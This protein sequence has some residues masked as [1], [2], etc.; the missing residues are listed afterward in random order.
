MADDITL[1]GT[2]PPRIVATDEDGSN[3]NYQWIKIAYGLDNVFNK[4][5]ATD[6][7]PVQFGTGV[8]LPAGTNTIGKVDI[9]AGTNMIGHVGGTDYKPV[10]ASQTDVILGASGAVGDYLAGLLIIPTT[11]GAGSVSIKDGNGTT[12]PVFNTGTLP[13]LIPFYVPIGAKCVNATTAGWKI[14]TGANV[15]V[16]AVGDFT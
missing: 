11:T 10:A 7:F 1:P 4:V 12:L 9:N 8:T 16:I 5:A 15:T 14:T 13:S 2:S 6:G 3:R